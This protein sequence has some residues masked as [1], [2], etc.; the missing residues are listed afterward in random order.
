[1][2][3]HPGILAEKSHGPGA[4]GAAVPRGLQSMGVRL[5]LNFFF[6]FTIFHILHTHTHTHTQ[7]LCKRVSIGTQSLFLYTQCHTPHIPVPDSFHPVY[8]GDCPTST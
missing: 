1:M 6:F 5:Q 2:A 3:T 7:C 4:W 8:K